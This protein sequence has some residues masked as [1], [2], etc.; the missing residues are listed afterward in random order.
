MKLDSV[1]GTFVAMLYPAVGMFVALAVVA[2][3]SST[4]QK[5]GGDAAIADATDAADADVVSNDAAVDGAVDASPDA[6]D[7]IAGCQTGTYDIDDNALTGTCGCEYAC[8]FVSA[9]DAYDAGFTDS[10]CDGGDG[11]VAACVYVSA[12]QGLNTNAGTRAQPMQ[13]IVAALQQAELNAVPFVCLSGEVYT[14]SYTV[15]SGVGLVGSFDHQDADFVFRRKAGI[16]TTVN[17]STLP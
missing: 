1:G 6:W 11:V 4:K 14:E 13:T 9:T 2:C 7:C 12:S 5:G 15:P 8:T 10:N 17:G 16:T 3:G